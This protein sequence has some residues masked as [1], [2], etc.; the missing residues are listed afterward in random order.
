VSGIRSPTKVSIKR[1]GKLVVEASV[2]LTYVDSLDE[3][4]FAECW[5]ADSTGCEDEPAKR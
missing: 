3:R 4:V 5:A 2:E 1:D